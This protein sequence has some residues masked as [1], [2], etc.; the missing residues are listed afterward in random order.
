MTT[1]FSNDEVKLIQEYPYTFTLQFSKYSEALIQSI[2]LSRILLGATA[3]DTYTSLTFRATSVQTI[4]QYHAQH[5]AIYEKEA[6]HT[7][8]VLKMM[9]D[10]ASQLNILITHFHKSFLGYTPENILVIDENKFVY[11]STE[12][13]HDIEEDS[14]NIMVTYPFSQRDL[15]LSPE[16][17]KT[18]E[19]PAKVHYKTAYYSL[20]AM[21]Q[22]VSSP[23][24]LLEKGEQNRYS[25]LEKKVST[26][27]PVEKVET[28]IKRCLH[29]I[30]E[31]RSI[32]FM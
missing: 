8:T 18:N 13:L 5:K 6:W 14:E 9:S 16:L 24:P 7:K 27:S 10:L 32:L 17:E 2:L 11:L 25:L 15:Y 1:L 3:S 28:I 23:Y 19:L 29:E 12:Y 22:E 26:H 20:G 31:R 4:P 21:M 30:P